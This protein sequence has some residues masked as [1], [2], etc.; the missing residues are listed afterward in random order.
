MTLLFRPRLFRKYQ[1]PLTFSTVQFILNFCSFLNRNFDTP[2]SEEGFFVMTLQRVCLD[3]ST[4]GGFNKPL[5][6]IL[7]LGQIQLFNPVF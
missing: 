5:L 7:F 2:I 4:Q 1:E 6:E 3:D